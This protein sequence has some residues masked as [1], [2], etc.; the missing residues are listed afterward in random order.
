MGFSGQRYAPAALYPRGKDPRYPLYR[1]LGGP[2]SR[3]GQRKKSFRLCQG[4]NLDR[5]VVQSVVRHT[6][7][8]TRLL[9]VTTY[10]D[11]W[12]W[13]QQDT[14]YR[15]L[16]FAK[17]KMLHLRWQPP[18]ACQWNIDHLGDFIFSSRNTDTVVVSTF[19]TTKTW[20]SFCRRS[21]NFV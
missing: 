20:M 8:A 18:L 16:K 6:D 15:Q 7:W 10:Q 5:P 17:Y 13:R 21:E 1:R 12:W 2:Q 9:T 3:S 11:V 19:E 14:L 4:S